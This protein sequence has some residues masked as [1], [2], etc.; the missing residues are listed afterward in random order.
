[1]HDT[2]IEGGIPY[3]AMRYVDGETLGHRLTRISMETTATE[4]SSFISFDDDEG[5]KASMK[6]SSQSSS[7]SIDRLELERTIAAF[8]KIALSTVPGEYRTR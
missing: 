2:G 7:S 5:T 6:S 1:V 3:I 8:E 4:P